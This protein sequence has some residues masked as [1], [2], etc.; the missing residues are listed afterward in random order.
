MFEVD[1][2][3]DDK[4]P[5]TDET[6]AKEYSIDDKIVDYSSFQFILDGKF[7]SF[8]IFLRN[9][10][11]QPGKEENQSIANCPY[12]SKLIIRFECKVHIIR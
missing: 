9:G 2:L 4:V 11:Q 7:P 8:F 10:Q 5:E 1:P 3:A 12:N 6:D